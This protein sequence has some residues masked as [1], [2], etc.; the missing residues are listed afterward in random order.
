MNEK[1]IIR[2]LSEGEESFFVGLVDS[3]QDENNLYFLL[4]YLPGGELLTHIKQSLS[5]ELTDSV[6][7]LAEILIALKQL[8]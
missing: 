5:L 2:K 8:H 6:F 4:E 1:G 3:M 7:Y